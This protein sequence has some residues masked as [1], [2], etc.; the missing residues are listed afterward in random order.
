MSKCAEFKFWPDF[1]NNFWQIFSGLTGIR[2]HAHACIIALPCEAD[3]L[4]I[5]PAVPAEGYGSGLQRLIAVPWWCIL[6][7]CTS[8]SFIY[9]SCLSVLSS[10]LTWFLKSFLTNFFRAD[11]D[12]NPCTCMHHSVALRG[13]RSNHSTSGAGRRVGSGLRRLIAVPWWCILYLCTSRSFI[14]RSCLSV[15]SS[16]L[17]WF[18]KSFLTNFFRANRDSNPCTCMHHSVARRTL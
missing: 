4:T 9:R 16:N 2:T 6:Y 18:L 10:N 7:L 15:L 11:R 13:G 3:A 5:L 12:S 17:T 8:R 1:W 14:Y